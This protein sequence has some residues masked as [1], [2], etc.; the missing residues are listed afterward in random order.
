MPADMSV[1]DELQR[2]NVFTD[3]GIAMNWT[4]ELAR[5]VRFSSDVAAAIRMMTPYNCGSDRDS[6]APNDIMWL[7][8]CLIMFG[9]LGRLIEEDTSNLDSICR[10]CGHILS[11]F[12]AY[13]QGGIAGTKYKGDSAGAFQRHSG[14][15]R[16]EEA[17]ALLRDMRDKATRAATGRKAEGEEYAS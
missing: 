4:G 16:L 15:V 17:T 5:L 10:E 8:D 9:E 12:Q 14:L 13:T 7:S 3:V 11:V 1:E 6:N 2:C